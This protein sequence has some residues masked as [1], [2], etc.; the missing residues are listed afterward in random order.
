MKKSAL[1]FTASFGHGHVQAAQVLK[2]ECEK[3]DVDT[4]IIDLLFELH[5]FVRNVL[6]FSYYRMLI[7]APSLWRFLYE[8]KGERELHFLHKILANLMQKKLLKFIQEHKPIFII[9]THPF[10]TIMLA[11]LK[12]KSIGHVPLYAVM[13]DFKFHP[14][15]LHHAIDHYFTADPKFKDECQAWGINAEKVTYS[16]IPTSKIDV[17]NKTKVA[18]KITDGP[19][20]VILITGG[21]QGIMHYKTLIR[22]LNDLQQKVMIVCMIGH[23][24]KLE[25]SI[26]KLRQQSKHELLIIPFTSHFSSYF[27]AANVVITKA[28]GLTLTEGLLCGKSML[29]FKP[30]PGHEEDNARFLLEAGACEWTDEAKKVP[31]IV[32]RLLKNKSHQ[33]LIDKAIDSLKKPTAAETIVLKIMTFPQKHFHQEAN[34]AAF[35]AKDE[36]SKQSL[37]RRVEQVK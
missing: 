15:F 25:A 22:A 5:P 20:P 32:E 23:N 14:F 30:L 7:Y 3:N 10:V 33:T 9:S 11:S 2:T 21:G 36:Q 8:Q 35:F 28:G 19:V 24:L 13:T 12:Q 34:D 16:G 37:S 31:V 18:L 29:I 4:L 1:I 17:F 6:T 26:N 27:Q